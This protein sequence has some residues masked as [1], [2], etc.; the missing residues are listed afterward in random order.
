MS[1]SKWTKGQSGNPQGKPSG[2][3]NK[4]N[5]EVKEAFNDLLQSNLTRIEAV[6]DFLAEEDPSAF[7]KYTIEIAKLVYPKGLPVE[8]TKLTYKIEIS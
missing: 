5:Q 1:S 6:M 3:K 2:A 8:S 7:V 4:T